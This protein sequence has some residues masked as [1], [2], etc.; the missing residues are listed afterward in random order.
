MR[1]RVTLKLLGAV[2]FVAAAT[3]LALQVHVGGSGASGRSCGSSLDV[4]TDRSG[5]E[6]WYAQDVND[7]PAGPTTRL[8]R[9]LECP[10]A[11][12]TRTIIAG[13]LGAAGLAAVVAALTLRQ[14]RTRH[15]ESVEATMPMRLRRLGATVTIIG[16]LLTLTGLAA[17]GLVLADRHATLFIYVTR[18]VVAA[19][20]LVVLAPVLALLIGGRALTILGRALENEE[21]HD[22][23]E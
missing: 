1:V 18:P 12:N 17:L 23:T 19:L 16:G 7:V 15:S 20:G 8:L 13:I 11:V 9:T 21:S 14:T 10:G 5:W 2:L 22:A 6:V 4:L 3:V